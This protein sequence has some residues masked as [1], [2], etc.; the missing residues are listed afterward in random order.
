MTTALAAGKE[1]D[2]YCT[3]CKLELGHRIVAI[4]GSQVKRVVCLTCGS[5]HNYRRAGVARATSGTSSP[6]TG[7]AKARSRSK[8]DTEYAA[9][10]DRRVLGQSSHSF[11][12]YSMNATFLEGDLVQH[13][14][15]G[16]GYV[17]A[18]LEG[19][20]VTIVFRDGAKTLAHSA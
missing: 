2:A 11:K 3:R 16:Q 6:R 4:V 7:Q 15:F 10:W 1:L 8:Q 18:V 14:K 20:K 9:E 12:P 5:E 17:A 13:S 19:S